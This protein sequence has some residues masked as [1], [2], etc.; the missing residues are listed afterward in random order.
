MGQ[1]SSK[2]S[3]S[4]TQHVFA[5][6]TPVRFS[7]ELVDALQASPE[8]DTT[9]SKDLESHIQ[10]RVTAELTRLEAEQTQAI[11]ELEE[12]ISESPDTSTEPTSSGKLSFFSGKD[13]QARAQSDKLRDLSR[14]SVQKTIEEL[15]KRLQARKLREDIVGDKE[16]EKAKEEVVSCLRLNDRRPLDCWQEVEAFKREVGRLEKGFLGKILD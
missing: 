8:T 7:P 9:R 4:G 1:E 6:D 5:A 15:R 10:S 16:V 2:A 12:R 11:R 14:E 3:P 13:E